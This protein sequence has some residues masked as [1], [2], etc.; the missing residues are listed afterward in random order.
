MCYN[1]VPLGWSQIQSDQTGGAGYC[2]TK[3]TAWG[4]WKSACY[5]S[6]FFDGSAASSDRYP[7][8]PTSWFKAL[9]QRDFP[10]MQDL[11][12]NTLRLYNA[13][14]TTLQ[15]TVDNVGKNGIQY[16]LGKEHITFMDMA[17]KYGF[18]VIFPLVGD[19]T[20]LTQESE[21]TIQQY[22][23]NQIDEVGN[24]TALLMWNFR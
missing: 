2:S 11:G 23:R 13:N 19:Q 1:P 4:D 16:P 8:G 17:D 3:K 9:W 18:K 12:V 10:I 6:D 20:I 15:Y 21:D 5:D 7:P 22:L 14:P 24:H